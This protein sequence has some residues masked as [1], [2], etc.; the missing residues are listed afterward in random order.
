MTFPRK[1][2]VIPLVLSAVHAWAEDRSSRFDSFFNPGNSAAYVVAVEPPID[3]GPRTVNQAARGSLLVS[4]N[5]RDTWSVT[6]RADHFQLSD[7]PALPGTGARFPDSLWDLQGGVAY[8]HKL[9]ERRQW[10]VTGGVGSASDH[11]FRS[12]HETEIQTTASYIKPSGGNNSWVFL[13]SYSNNRS[14][15]NGIPLPGFAYVLRDPDKR[16]QVTVGFPFITANVKPDDNWEARA[17]LFG[18]TSQSAEVSRRV[19]GPVRA[20]A[21]FDHGAQSWFRANRDDNSRRLIY[22]E[23]KVVAGLRA[24]AGP[25]LIDFSGGRTFG[26]R[27]FEAKDVRSADTAKVHLEKGW[28]LALSLSGRFGAGKS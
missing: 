8:I 18:P 12:I 24:S 28:I 7:S 16:Y 3:G 10:G 11:P 22:D 17:S 15:A 1:L 19:G 27:L 21:G 5:D 20:Y 14:F 6:G 9:G 26:R 23:E 4:K 13:L 2:V 25:A